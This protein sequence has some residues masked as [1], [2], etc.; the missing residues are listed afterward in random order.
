MADLFY[1]QDSRSNVGSRA[2]FWRAGGGYTSNL[3]EAEE[4]TRDR[5]V[6]QYL[7]RE[8][9]LPWPVA[10]VRNLAQ[11]GVDHQDLDL[12]REQALAAACADERIYVAYARAWD[13]NCLI[14]M[15]VPA[16]R[17]SNLADARTWSL[18][19]AK[20]FAARGY[21]PWPKGYIDQHS[22]PVALAATLDHKRALRSAGL[23][24]PKVKQQ[25]TRSY[26]NLNNC[27]G[28]GR[29]LSERQRFQDCP[30]CGAWNAP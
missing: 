14:W 25:R 7:C 23:K 30:N 29:F 16:G 4:F 19:H 2:M 15:S 27:E 10:Y 22:R 9:D 13:G 3:D 6:R 24:L 17:G 28:C 11:I 20:G 21:L 12:P 26:S 8:T 18:D 5:A 1:L